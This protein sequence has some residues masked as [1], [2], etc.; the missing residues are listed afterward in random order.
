VREG[1]V[2]QAL[3]LLQQLADPQGES[4]TRRRKPAGLK[5]RKAR[6]ARR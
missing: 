4:T 6:P 2:A 3:A 1:S 5:K